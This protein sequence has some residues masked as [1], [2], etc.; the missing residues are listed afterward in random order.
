MCLVIY[1]GSVNLQLLLQNTKYLEYCKM[2]RPPSPVHGGKSLRSVIDPVI[3]VAFYYLASLNEDF[4]INNEKLKSIRE[5]Q[6]KGFKLH[7]NNLILP[8]EKKK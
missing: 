5:L 7:Q 3:G 6:S 1:Y 8:K 2:G 4:T